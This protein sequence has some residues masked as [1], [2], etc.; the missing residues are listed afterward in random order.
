M[1]MRCYMITNTKTKEERK[2][3]E[4]ETER[5]RRDRFLIHCK[6]QLKVQ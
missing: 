4:T 1:N 5:E 2:K 6:E 3:R